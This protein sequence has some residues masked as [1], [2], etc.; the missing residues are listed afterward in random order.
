[1]LPGVF[2]WYRHTLARNRNYARWVE[3]ALS[4]YYLIAP[5]EAIPAAMQHLAKPPGNG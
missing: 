5:A 4:A 2:G 3:Y 1:M